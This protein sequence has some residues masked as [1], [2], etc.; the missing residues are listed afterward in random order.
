MSGISAT[1]VAK[2]KC[3]DNV[4]TDVLLKACIALQYDIRDIC[5]IEDGGKDR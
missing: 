5:E 1:I 3:N 2:L 4:I